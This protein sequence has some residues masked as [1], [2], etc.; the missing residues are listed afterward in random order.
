MFEKLTNIPSKP[1]VYT[2]KNLKERVLYVGKAKDLRNRLRSYF[3]KSLKLNSRKAAMLRDVKDFTYIVTDNELE[4]LVLEANL[5]KQY[6]PRFN[7]VL[8]DDKNYPYLKL[9]VDEQW[10]RLEVVRRIKKDGALYFGPYVPAGSMW[11]T[12]AFIRRNFQIRNCKYSLDRSMRPCIHYQM[13]RCPAPCAGLI[14]RRKY[15]K[16]IEE[17]RLFLE[18]KKKDLLDGLERKMI[19]LSEELRFEEAAKIRDRIKALERALELQKVVAPELGDIDVI[20]FYREGN[21]VSFKVFFIRNGIMVGSR[22]FFIKNIENTSDRE[23]IRTFITQFYSKEIIPSSEII[24]PVLPEELKSLQKWLSQR[25]GAVVKIFAP[26]AGK[27]KELSDM[28]LKNARLAFRDKKESRLDDLLNDIRE[29]LKLERPPEDIGV[30]DVS[31]IAGKESVGAFVYWREGEFKKDMYRRLRIKTV[32]GVDDYSMIEEIL[33]RTMQNLGGHMPDLIIIDGGKGQLEIA[34][35]VIDKNAMLFHKMPQL[36]AIAKDPDRAY[37]TTSEETVDLNDGSRAS[38]LLKKIRDEAH[39]FAVGYHRKLREKGLMQS[40]LEKIPGIGKKRRLALLRKFGSIEDIRKASVDE[41]AGIKGFNRKVAEKLLECF[42]SCFLFLISYFLLFASTSDAA[43]KIY[44]Q[45]GS[46]ITGVK[47]YEKSHGEIRFFFEG[48]MIAIQEGDV[49]RIEEDLM[50]AKDIKGKEKAPEQIEEAGQP[51]DLSPAADVDVR[52]ASLRKQIEEINK[53]ISNIER[54]E[55][56]LKEMEDELKRGKYK[57]LIGKKR[58]L[59]KDKDKLEEEL[60]PLLEEKK[61]L[62]EERRMIEDEIRGL[63]E[64]LRR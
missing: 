13:E 40:P 61:M 53:K 37:L 45:N 8:R 9:T 44:L 20:G 32:Q 63:E 30:F 15:L 56:E 35:R 2:F 51:V 3:Q 54:K 43:Y 49:V 4:A 59:K 17:I 50:Y 5:I 60:R 52:I 12:L 16:L 39:R 29:R 36:I 27:K 41:I 26:Q 33:D 38:L 19:Q 6:R 1:G 25:K 21:A 18:G 14:S 55:G 47:S 48:G 28:A 11:E 62:I 31:T 24:T 7:V 46:V 10:P 23:L 22:D 34:K 58:R 57:E 42:T 64:E